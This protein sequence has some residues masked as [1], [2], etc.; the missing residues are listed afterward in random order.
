MEPRSKDYL[1]RFISPH[2]VM[3]PIAPVWI[4]PILF[5]YPEIVLGTVSDIAI[6]ALTGEILGWTP[7]SEVNKNAEQLQTN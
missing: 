4:V 6:N 2:L 3:F 1:P 5:A 7:F